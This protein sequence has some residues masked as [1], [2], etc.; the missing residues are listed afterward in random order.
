MGLNGVFTGVSKVKQAPR[1]KEAERTSFLKKRSKKLL[2]AA[3][4]WPPVP[5]IA[6]FGGD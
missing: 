2:L 4:A 1:D 5:L 6:T 3:G